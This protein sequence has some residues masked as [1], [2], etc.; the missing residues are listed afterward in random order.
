MIKQDVGIVAKFSN[1]LLQHIVP[2]HKKWYLGQ[3][4]QNW[5]YFSC[6]ST[7]AA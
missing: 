5:R 1:G 2:T 6:G 3:R 7:L 4:I